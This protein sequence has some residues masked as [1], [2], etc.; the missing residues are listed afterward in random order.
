MGESTPIKTSASFIG[1]VL[2]VAL[3]GVPAPVRADG[4]GN[5]DA[6]PQETCGLCHGL[7]GVSRMSKFP[8][9]AG[10]K[11]AYIEKQVVDFRAGRRSNDGGQMVAIVTE[12]TEQQIGEAA[13]YFASLAPPPPIANGDAEKAGALIGRLFQSGDAARGILPCAPCHLPGAATPEARAP[14]Y[15]PRLTAQHPDY[16]AKQL[17]DFRG[18]QRAND[19]TGTMAAIASALSEAEIDAFAIYLA[20]LPRKTAHAD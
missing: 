18:G 7:D 11:A 14:D 9:L 15:A 19:E 8:R 10:Q 13:R 16:I 6:P 20:A 4:I 2:A 17:R 3:T 12:F 1:F 5:E